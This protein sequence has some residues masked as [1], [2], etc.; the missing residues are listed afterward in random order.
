M[1]TNMSPRAMKMIGAG[2]LALSCLTL[3]HPALEGAQALANGLTTLITEHVDQDA[4]KITMVMGPI[5]PDTVSGKLGYAVGTDICPDQRG[6]AML[7]RASEGSA[8]GSHGCIVVSPDTAQVRVT[9]LIDNA[10]STAE[11]WAVKR[12][13]SG[14]T[15]RRPDG[16]TVMLQRE[17]QPR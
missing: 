14:L 15:F 5:V 1:H 16:S 11:A 12:S 7:T 17:N 10:A 9:L 3:L 2:A 4:Q 8:A 13:D 6:S